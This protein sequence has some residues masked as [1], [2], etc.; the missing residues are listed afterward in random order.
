[1]NDYKYDDA[2]IYA[3]KSGDSELIGLITV[4]IMI[5]FIIGYVLLKK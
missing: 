1:M 2:Y 3:D 5:A 4:L